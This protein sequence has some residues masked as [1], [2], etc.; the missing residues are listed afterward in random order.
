MKES[1][2]DFE[3]LMEQKKESENTKEIIYFPTIM[4]NDDLKD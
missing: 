4:N 1:G 2:Y 3:I